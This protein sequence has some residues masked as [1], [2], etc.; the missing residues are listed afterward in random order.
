[1][2]RARNNGH[3]LTIY[4]N[5]MVKCMCY[6]GLGFNGSFVTGATLMGVTTGQI[7]LA[8]LAIEVGISHAASVMYDSIQYL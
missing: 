1:V 2:V 8:V 4:V 6:I 7:S 5:F 3:G